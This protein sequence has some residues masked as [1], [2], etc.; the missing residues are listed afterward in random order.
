MIDHKI[1]SIAK[2]IRPEVVP[3][4]VLASLIIALVVLAA[5]SV[6]LSSSFGVM[7][8]YVFLY[9]AMVGN[10][11]TF[12]LLI[13]AGRPLNALLL[14]QGFASAES[15]EGLAILRA[16]TLVGIWLLG[17]GLYFFARLH[18][19][20]F[21]CSLAIACGV[22]LLPSFQVY[23]SWA[24]HFT[25]PFAGAIALLSA[26]TLTPA[27]AMRERSR[28]LAVCLSTVLLLVA[29]LIYQPI[30]MLFCVGI[31]MSIFATSNISTGWKVGRIIDA[32]AAFV[33]A[34]LLGLIV[35]KIGQHVYSNGSSRYGLLQDFQGKLIWFFTEPLANA[36]ALY[37]VRGSSSLN[38][39]IGVMLSLG[40]LFLIKRLGLKAAGLM[41]IYSVLCVLGSYAPNLATAENWASYRSLGALA[42]AV[43]V[44]LVFLLAE[45]TIYIREK[46]VA[47][48]P[49]Q[50]ASKYLW[51][52]LVACLAV[53]TVQAQ[54]NVLN[55]FVLPN[56]TEL[57]NL[58]SN[59]S[60]QKWHR[61]EV[62]KIIVRPSSWTDSSAR[63]IAY[64]E[65]GMP[66]STGAGYA[67]A[68]VEIV[69]RAT[70]SIPNA[71]VTVS[72][73]SVL[74]PESASDKNFLVDFPSLVT[75][76]R[77]KT[78]SFGA[79]ARS[80]NT[81]SPLNITDDNWAAGVWVNESNPNAY[82]FVYGVFYGEK[83]LKVG[84]K[85][86]FKESGVRTVLRIES[87]GGY[88]NVLVDGVPL[89][90]KDGYP[91]AI[92]RIF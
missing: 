75:S 37:S 68:I 79:Q 53:F 59:L 69:L 16:I 13:G 61:S 38:L 60:G 36:L 88:I 52:V 18:R 40:A 62:T 28:I 15:I 89:D 34:M 87:V 31:L 50:F 84:D 24:Q 73:D 57:N 45:P 26:F 91:N 4:G 41:F 10:T 29:I 5:Y 25:T 70:N 82:S 19:V 44:L 72:K 76:Q 47:G 83:E 56:V 30:A 33:I 14:S 20:S 3:Q 43:V 22:V 23:A 74:A 64:D 27:C 78:V 65:F 63:P 35:F 67:K 54:S 9:N 12:T 48:A 71:V 2:D 66:S 51:L 46:Y 11:D 42:A 77:F 39:S 86:S 1:D 90:R 92:G 6:V 7:D 55:A 21:I 8:D 80:G 81:I 17:C 58:A 32:A 85:L 49:L